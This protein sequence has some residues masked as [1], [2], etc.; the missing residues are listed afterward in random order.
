[1]PPVYALGIDVGTSTT[2]VAVVEIGE[3]V[4]EVRVVRRPTPNDGDGIR[5]TVRETVAAAVEDLVVGAIGI[6]SMAE[7]G[8]L[9]DA[10]GRSIGPLLRWDAAGDDPADGRDLRT[11]TGVPRPGKST[12][13]LLS[14]AA[15]ARAFSSWA[16][17]AELGALAVV[18][19]AVTDPTLALRTMLASLPAL[20]DAVEWDDELVAATGLTVDALPEILA[21]GATVAVGADGA[22]L[23]VTPGT[24]VTMAGHDHAVAAWGTG[25]REPDVTADS[26]GTAEAI[27]RVA[28]GSVDREAAIHAGM[29]V[30]R[31]VDGARETILG[32]IPAASRL[33]SDLAGRIAEGTRSASPLSGTIVLPSPRGRQSPR[34]DPRA[35]L[36]AVERDGTPAELPSTA[37]E[38]V[39]AVTV[40]L[41]LHARWIAETQS[42]LLGSRASRTAVAGPAHAVTGPWWE[43]KRA[44]AD[45]PLHRATAR[46][47]VASAAALL[48]AV[49]A[50]LAD[51]ALRLAEERHPPDPHPEADAAYAAFV[52]AS[53]RS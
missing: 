46:E 40:G 34:P 6:A 50:G 17:A 8:S 21:P 49:R 38:L 13:A 48:A 47:P 29:S 11:R 28:P 7:S 18:G 41:A 4:R 3:R 27:I 51:P 15:P 14:R 2:K 1:M 52:S 53:L 31:T 35:R 43:A 37:D 22:Q 32:G 23:G 42:D 12:R 30:G 33:L 45:A 10:D 19:R 5:A 9:L 20:G 26:I 36:L 16:G 44:V 24:P 25:M 39:A